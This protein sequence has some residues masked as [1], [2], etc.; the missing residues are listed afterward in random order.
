MKMQ[1]QVASP[2]DILEYG[3]LIISH[4]IIWTIKEIV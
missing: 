1:L 2:N 3:K 4:G